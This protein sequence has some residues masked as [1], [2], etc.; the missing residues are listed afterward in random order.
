[1]WSFNFVNTP[2]YRYG[3][4]V[5]KIVKCEKAQEMIK[6]A[7]DPDSTVSAGQ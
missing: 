6:K 3:A 1:M 2:V 5:I 4:P 7:V